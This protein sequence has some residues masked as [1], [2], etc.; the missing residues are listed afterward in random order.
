MQETSVLDTTLIAET[1]PRAVTWSDGELYLLDQTLLP[2]ETVM[3]KQ[4]TAE[5]VWES[6][7]VLKVRGAP[8]IGVAGAY[9]LCVAMKGFQDLGLTDFITEMEKQA[10]YLDSSRPTAVNLGW[11]LRRMVRIAKSAEVT[12]AAEL[13]KVLVTEAVAIHEEDKRLCRGM[14]NNGAPLIKEGMGILTHCNAGS[15]ATSELG[16]ATAPMYVA[17][18][19][20]V[21]FRVY[22]DE[23]RPL[24]QGARLTSW[25]LQKSGIDVTLIT[26]N[27]AAHIMSQ[28]L[29]DMVIV[30]TDRVAANGD[31]A[32]KIGTMGVAILAKHFGIP[33]YVACPSSTIDHDTPTGAGIP[34]E[35]REDHEVTNFGARRT[36]PENIKVRNP[37]FDVTPNELVAGLI[38]EKQIITAPY[39]ENINRIF[40][41]G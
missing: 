26:D 8:A 35:E 4:E 16:T 25:E 33:F 31:V 3:E 27:M 21:K 20:G 9:G 14:G 1:L 6:I 18:S 37:A 15:L 34:I 36:A 13:Y 19:Q 40:G 17:H 5:Q 7:R 10:A 39:T 29:I 22:A 38:T 41:Q 28:G 24:L 30:G 11:G 12:S 23:T 32:N 2:Q